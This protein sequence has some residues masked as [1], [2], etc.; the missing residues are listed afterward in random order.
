MKHLFI[1]N[2]VAGKGKP[3]KLIPEI[4]KYFNKYGSEYDIKVTQYPGQ[5]T[6]IVRQYAGNA[7]IHNELRIYAVGGDG[8][9]NE[10][11]NG[12]LQ[13]ANRTYCSLAIIP[14]GSG[15]DFFKSSAGTRP[16]CLSFQD[17]L[18]CSANGETNPIDI[19]MVNGR[20]FANIASFGFDAEVVFH[21]QK[22]KKISWLPANLCYFASIIT[23]MFRYKNLH[24][25]VT[26][27]NQRIDDKF[28]LLAVANGKY[29]GGGILPA[30]EAKIDDGLLDVC[31]IHQKNFF[32]IL[33][34]LP[35][36]VKGQHRDVPGVSF[37]KA[38]ELKAVCDR[39]IA[40]N[41]DG[42]IIQGKEAV[43]QVVPGGINLVA[44]HFQSDLTREQAA[45]SSMSY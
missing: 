29:Y 32:E 18:D 35:K 21:A 41:L 20:Y 42:E 16:H 12:I 25:V 14:S 33:T 5:A 45:A 36:Y 3:L 10:I 23:T 37:F 40:L 34:T 39:E 22:I 2:P 44:P 9:V 6:D 27:D 24:M 43:F 19:A 38:R 1:I 15:N 28:L 8:T 13:S 7:N 4:Q 30:P 31:L 26:I 17:L 11:V